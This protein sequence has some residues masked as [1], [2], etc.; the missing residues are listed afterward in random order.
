LAT[1]YTVPAKRDLVE[2][3]V[4]IAE[5]NVDAADALNGR[6]RAVCDK[7]DQSPALGK[8]R[9]ELGAEI[10]S[11]AI[12]SY[13]IYYRVTPDG[14]RILRIVHGARDAIR[15]LGLS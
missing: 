10:R 12:G 1:V 9:P 11:F 4:Y 2:I 8:L 13:V 5:G 6:I 3:W 7:L 14:V 15:L